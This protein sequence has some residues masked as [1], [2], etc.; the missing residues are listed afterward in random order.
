ME[1]SGDGGQRRRVA[2]AEGSEAGLRRWRVVV[3]EG[4]GG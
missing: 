2:A 4:S 3:A 1:G